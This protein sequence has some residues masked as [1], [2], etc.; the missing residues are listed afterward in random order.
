MQTWAGCGIRRHRRHLRRLQGRRSAMRDLAFALMLLAVLPLALARPLNA[1]LLWGWTSLLAPTTYF[2]GFMAGAR[3]NL[4]CAVLT[5]GMVL[6]GRVPWR[7]YQ[8]NT[9]L[10]LY[11]LLAAHASLA[12]GLAYSGNPH[13][14]QYYEF[15]LKGLAF[16][17]VMP[18]FVRERVHFHALLI[19]IA[20]GLGI[21][22]V[23][24]GLKTISSAGGHNMLGP[25]GTMLADRN[26]LSV[27]LAM[28]L[29]LL[30]YLQGCTASR[31]LRLGYWG[32]L[33][34]VVVAILGGGSRGG[35]I[36][37][38]VLGAWLLLT[39][40]RKG[41][42]LVMVL[43]TVLCFQAFA[44]ESI[45]QRMS[46]IEEAQDD[47]SFMGRV[48]AWRISSAIALAHP[49]FGGGLHAVQVQWIWD[50]FKADPGL[51][52]FLHLPVPTFTAKA[53]HSIYFE[54]MGDMGFVGLAIFIVILLRALW[55]C[56]AIGRLSQRLGAPYQWARDMADALMLAVLVYMVG[57]AAVSM[58]Y[59]EGIYMFVMLVE[60]L[61]L[62]VRR[63]AQAT[64]PALGPNQRGAG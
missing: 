2:Y 25:A 22:G 34:L 50:I 40:R 58:G 39:T 63:A 46:T 1:Y 19:V 31:W 26:Q 8:R 55:G 13:N 36:S 16:A 59:Y 3:V 62:H 60:L 44:P 10:W 53:A 20:L 30:L 21:H 35:F 61:H 56:R 28:V 37:L 15:L 33:V 42:A 12:Y 9:L 6:V 52:G 18:L 57:G 11:L 38:S 45:T 48:Y 41:L 24:N 17:V 5:L 7:S 23:L 4:L 49:V 29:P 51:L 47:S 54:V 27:A 32:A 14:G 43:V 64:Q